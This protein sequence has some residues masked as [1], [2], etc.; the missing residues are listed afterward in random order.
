MK[1]PDDVMSK[2]VART[3]LSFMTRLI[4]WQTNEVSVPC[5][6]PRKFNTCTY[7]FES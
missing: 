3:C 5:I 4:L 1:T 6:E 7:R 2:A